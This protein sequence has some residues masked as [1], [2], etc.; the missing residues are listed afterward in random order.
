MYTYDVVSESVRNPHQ[1]AEE[2]TKRSANG[3]EVVQITFDGAAWFHAFIR[4]AGSVP[5]GPHAKAEEL[6]PAVT[7]STPATPV[8]TASSPSAAATGATP[9]V[10]ADWH[11]DPSGRFELR[12]WNGTAWTEHVATGGKQ[13]IDPI[14]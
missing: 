10:P 1:L 14:R 13:S 7:V 4:H 6:Q 5:V 12:Y 11:K 9:N 3:W 8:A 2:L